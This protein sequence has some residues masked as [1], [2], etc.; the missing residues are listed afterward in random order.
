MIRLA[1]LVVAV[2]AFVAG[3]SMAG[4]FNKVV[5]IGDKAPTFEKLPNVDDSMLNSADLKNDVVVVIVTCNKC[6]VAVAYED[7]MIA[8]T[9]KFKGKVDVVAVNV[10]AAEADGPDKMKERAKEKGFNFP[11]VY[12]ASQNL[13]KSLGAKVTPEVFV[14][15]KD[16]KIVYMG[17]FDDNIKE[18]QVKS[19]YLE[20]TVEA[21][22]AG[23]KVELAETKAFG[24][25][26][27]YNRK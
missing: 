16:R 23:K 4:E 17:A 10:N 22:L 25:G 9:K 12:D 11:Y 27:G 24:C 14:F 19:K 2:A 6:P 26:V 5:S 18:D 15:N 1:S 3:P 20:N 8:F 13:A 7:R 21:L